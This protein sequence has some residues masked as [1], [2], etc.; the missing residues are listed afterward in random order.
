MKYEFKFKLGQKVRDKITFFEGIVTGMSCWVTGC[1]TVGIKPQQLHEGKTID[2][3]W[4]DEVRLELVD[5]SNILEEPE[6][7]KGKTPKTPGGPQ[8]VPRQR[9][10]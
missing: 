4:F 10:D 3:H 2:S 8:D 6:R 5:G 9:S 7:R 1:N